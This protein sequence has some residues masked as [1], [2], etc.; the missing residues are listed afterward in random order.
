M[1]R[2]RPKAKAASISGGLFHNKNRS[3]LPGI[4]TCKSSFHARLTLSHKRRENRLCLLFSVIPSA[5]RAIQWCVDLAPQYAH[6]WLDKANRLETTGEPPK[7][8]LVQIKK[9]CY[10]CVLSWVLCSDVRAMSLWVV[11]GQPPINYT[12]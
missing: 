7:Q 9:I 11:L 6:Y 8:F 1:A 2:F 12:I 4:S 5:I 10:F 3:A